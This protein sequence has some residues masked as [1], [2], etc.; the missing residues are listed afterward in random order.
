MG[1]LDW[2]KGATSNVE[3]RGDKIWLSKEAKLHGIATGLHER[4]SASDRPSVFI[5]VAHFQDCLDDLRQIIKANGIGDRTVV[6]TLAES[7]MAAVSPGTTLHESQYIE[8][9]SAERHLLVA[10]DDALLKSLSS[11]GCRCRITHH[12]SL[13]DSLL[14]IFAAS[15][16]ENT[17]RKLGMQED[18]AI[19][20]A[21]VARRIRTTQIKIEKSASSD[22]PAKSAEQWLEVNCPNM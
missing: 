6:M 15:W 2:L 16:V 21:M 14:Q 8:V 22:K 11:L 17:L 10:H 13:E 7:L 1:F 4:L 3:I 9:V 12:L 19:E 5:M 20:S 18:E